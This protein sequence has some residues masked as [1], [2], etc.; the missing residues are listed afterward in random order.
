[1]VIVS[2]QRLEKM[3]EVELKHISNTKKA[4][5]FFEA[6]LDRGQNSPYISTQEALDL[7]KNTPD[8][9]FPWDKVDATWK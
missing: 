9:D 3:K 6:L 5:V 2:R 8:S 4:M 7:M 1:M